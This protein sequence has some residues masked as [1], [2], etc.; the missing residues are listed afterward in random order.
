MLAVVG[1]WS[2]RSIQ[3][4]FYFISMHLLV[5]DGQY[6][7]YMYL[8]CTYLGFMN[9]F[10]KNFY[11]VRYLKFFVLSSLYMVYLVMNVHQVIN[12]HLGPTSTCVK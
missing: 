9:D 6:I 5:Q 12:A 4:L 11:I 3:C 7:S 1:A 10:V 2:E 8:S